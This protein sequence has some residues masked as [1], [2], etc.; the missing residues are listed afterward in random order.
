MSRLF[1]L[2]AVTLLIVLPARRTDAALIFFTTEAAFD[3]AA[4]VLTV[5]TFESG[6]VGAGSATSCT[7]PVSSSSGSTCFPVGGLA[8]GASYDAAAVTSLDVVV[9]GANFGSVGNTS[10]VFGANAFADTTNIIFTSLVDAVGFDVF[11]GPAAG[12][13]LISVFD[14]GNLLLGSTTI[15]APLGGTFFGVISTSDSIGRVNIASQA[16]SPGELIDNV[17]FGVAGATAPEPA[18][19]LLLGIGVIAAGA[20][21]RRL[22]ASLN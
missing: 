4:P 17:E 6:L 3:L 20:R 9:L 13:V 12:N 15:F 11:A 5:E 22:R 2:L 21:R 1:T 10:K 18:A 16:A 14:T 7:G 8:P 19:L